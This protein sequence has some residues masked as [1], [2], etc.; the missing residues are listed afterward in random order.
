MQFG[1]GAHEA[2]G[3]ALL[4][5]GHIL[6][7]QEL[8]GSRR[9]GDVPVAGLDYQA[10]QLG[11]RQLEQPHVGRGEQVRVLGPEVRLQAAHRVGQVQGHALLEDLGVAVAVGAALGLQERGVERI[12]VEGRFHLCSHRT[13]RRFT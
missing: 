8:G 2:L 10:L 3:E 6:G 11:R 1:Q 5:V 12:V 9:G 4:L 13:V 7:A